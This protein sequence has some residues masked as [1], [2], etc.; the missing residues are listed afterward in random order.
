MGGFARRANFFS[1]VNLDLKKN[2]GWWKTLKKTL[3]EGGFNLSG[4]RI[5]V[6][7][8]RGCAPVSL[9]VFIRG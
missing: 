3:A 7:I 8:N 2:V 6:F 1:E 9:S 5:L 4:W